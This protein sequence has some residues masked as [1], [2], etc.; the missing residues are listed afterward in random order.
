MSRVF[1]SPEVLTLTR[2]QTLYRVV[3]EIVEGVTGRKAPSTIKKGILDEQ[4]LDSI[5]IYVV[6]TKREKLAS[7]ELNIDWEKHRLYSSTEGLK[8]F[9][10]NPGESVSHQVSRAI[11]EI[12]RFIKTLE[13]KDVF[14][15]VW[16]VVRSVGLVDLQEARRR[17]GFAEGGSKQLE[18]AQ[19]KYLRGRFRPEQL[20]ELLIEFRTRVE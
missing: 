5:I 8:K 18:W 15:E 16:Y 4:L 11:S 13:T 1:L 9:L 7:V 3:T 14:T 12:L 2:T 17:L 6:N 19:G 20:N 10:F